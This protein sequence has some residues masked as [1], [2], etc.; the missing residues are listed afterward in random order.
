LRRAIPLLI[1]A[2]LAPLAVAQGEPMDA[3]RP[4]LTLDPTSRDAA[5][6]S[7]F[8]VV[9]TFANPLDAPIT[10]S[11]SFAAP[12]GVKLDYER[13]EIAVAA[14]ARAHVNATILLPADANVTHT[15]AFLAQETAESAR[16]AQRT[17]KLELREAL[18]VRVGSPRPPAAL[19]PKLEIR[20]EPAI[21]RVDP[22]SVATARLVVLNPGGAIA[23]PDFAF[24]PIAGFDIRVVDPPPSL[25]TGRTEITIRIEETAA[26]AEGARYDTGV[27]LRGVGGSSPFQ[28]VAL[29]AVP[30]PPP[31]EAAAPAAQPLDERVVVAA[32]LAS[33]GASWTALWLSRHKWLPLLAALYT[34]LRPSRILDHPLRRA[35]VDLVQKEPGISFSEIARR[36]DIAPGQLT[37][38]ARMLEKAGI[39]FSSPHGQTRRFFHVGHGRLETVAPLA[40]RALLAL[41]ERPMRASDLAKALGVSRQALH[42]H[43]KQLVADGKL[44]ALSEGGET[45]LSAAPSSVAA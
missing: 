6:G 14:H 35:I 45:V 17:T 38:H 9:A 30:A 34:R 33:M 27:T 19:A 41:R 29:A 40:E 8:N 11:L 26:H 23:A 10:W 32:A 16:A 39:V 37:H 12:P 24:K 20:V 4:S 28:V 5:P 18:D 42:Y 22:E 15:I 25:P 43:V 36:L 3:A 21:V 44:V 2:V 31:V 1:L 13:W 7:S